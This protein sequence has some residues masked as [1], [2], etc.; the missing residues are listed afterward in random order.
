VVEEQN[1]DGFPS[2][3]W[4]QSPLHGFLSHQPHGPAGA[5][6]RRVAAHH[7]D[8][9]LFLA[10]F[11][12]RRRAGAL[13]VVERRFQAALLVAMADLPNSLRREGNRVG[14]A[15][16]TG[17]LSQLQERQGAKDDTNLLYAAA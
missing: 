3:A 4:N 8:D 15:R 16:R 2:H 9:P 12:H 14:N 17:A 7:G 5:A 1:P 13:L 6:S 11:Q 10:V